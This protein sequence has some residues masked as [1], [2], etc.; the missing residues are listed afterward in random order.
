MSP[1][2]NRFV[3]AVIAL[4]V[5]AAVGVLA[6]ESGELWLPGHNELLVFGMCALLGELVPLKVY[7][8]G[9][10]GETTTS[11]TFAIALLIA[12]GPKAALVG[13]LGANLIA[14]LVRDKPARK[15]AFN[16]AQYAISVAVAGMVLQPARAR[17]PAR[18]HVPLRARRPAGDLRRVAGVL[19]RQHVDRRGRDR[20]GRGRRDLAPPR[21]GLV[22]AGLHDRPDAR[23]LADR[24]A[25]GRLLAAADHPALPAALRDPPRRPRRDREGAPGRPRRA[26][27]AAQPRPVPRPRR[28]GDPHRPPHGDGLHG[29]ADG[30]QPLQ[31]DQRHPGPPPGR[32]APAGGRRAAAR[33]A[34]RERHGRAAR[35]RRVR[36]R[37]ARRRR[38][39]GRRR[40]RGGRARAPA[41]AV[42][43]RRDHAAG[44]RLDRARRLPRARRGR[45]DADPARRHRHVRREER[46]RRVR[47]FDASQDHHSP[48]R[49]AHRRRAARRDRAR[50]ARARLP[51]EGRPAH[52]AD[53]RRRGA[54]P[55]G[56][57]RARP[58]PPGRVRPDRRADRADHRPDLRGARRRAGARRRVA[59][60]RPRPHGRGEPLRA[61]VPGRRPG[62]GDPAP[63]GRARRPARP[64]GARDHRVDAHA[65]TRAAPARR[66]SGSRAIGV[67][68]A[69]DDFGTGYSSL[70]HLKRLPVDTIK[71]D[72]SFVLDMADDE[73][74]DGD[75]ALDDRARAQPR[76][77]R[78]RGGRRVRAIWMRLAALGCDLGAG[79]PPRAAAATR[80]RC[81]R[82]WTPREASPPPRS[83]SL[84]SGTDRRR[85]E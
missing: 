74:D 39:R 81:S 12:G 54:R 19:R 56:A 41:R 16:L 59:R 34:A 83:A 29:D 7:R 23:P 6:G 30:P 53:R 80:T 75:R 78:R 47:V 35:R 48:R 26:H 84:A 28:A 14:D 3:A 79:V 2:L 58:R 15:I 42:P 82:C 44:R 63:A 66:S 65:R 10:E 67:G 71:I 40:R 69:V 72:K 55:L 20:D 51:A 36:H 62:R 18:R 76:P 68:L 38:P 37:A 17:D 8:R 24:R 22:L 1:H 57:P 43:R 64:A 50:R 61:L 77:A 13:L 31:G 49:L 52:R 25:R 11:T 45:R 21:R 46:L 4:G 85:D 5:V 27:R 73:A 9:A 32:P 60:A 33:D 70:A